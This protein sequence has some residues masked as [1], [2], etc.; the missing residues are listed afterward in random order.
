MLF[1]RHPAN[2]R[3]MIARHLKVPNPRKMT[4]AHIGLPPNRSKTHRRLGSQIR[5]HQRLP[6]FPRVNPLQVVAKQMPT[7][8]AGWNLVRRRKTVRT[9]RKAPAI[10][11]KQ[12]KVQRG[13]RQ[14]YPRHREVRPS[15]VR[16]DGGEPRVNHH[17][18]SLS[19]D[20]A[21][22]YI[23]IVIVVGMIPRFVARIVW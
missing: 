1:R 7:G 10:L 11:R 17:L 19:C 22:V 9:S 12:Q 18:S 15:L 20:R 4:A 23:L 14:L 3:T 13:S 8:W 2:R 6:P 5:A 21:L 16:N